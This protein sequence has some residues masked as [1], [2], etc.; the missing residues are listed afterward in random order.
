MA[1]TEDFEA[2]L[3]LSIATQKAQAELNAQ[4]EADRRAYEL[5]FE[6]RRTRL[7]ML[8]TAK[9]TLVENKRNLP[10]ADRSI[11]ED[12]IIAYAEKLI[13]FVNT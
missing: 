7:E 4:V 11:S 2:Q 3:E 10:V 12:E 1:M 9:E 6:Q 5:A 13:K 8:R